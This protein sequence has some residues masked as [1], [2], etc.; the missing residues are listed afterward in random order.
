MHIY[1]EC[2]TDEMNI[3]WGDTHDD[4]N[5]NTLFFDDLF[6]PTPGFFIFFFI[7]LN[8]LCKQIKRV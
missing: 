1:D 4:D 2:K 8:I 7:V 3:Y 5:V 6:S